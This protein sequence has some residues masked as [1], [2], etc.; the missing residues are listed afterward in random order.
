MLLHVIIS[1]SKRQMRPLIVTVFS[2]CIFLTLKC[3]VY[4]IGQLVAYAHE[5]NGLTVASLTD[6]TA[7]LNKIPTGVSY[8]F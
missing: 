7:P 4:L 1:L 8:K 6:D 5:E 3:F 2:N